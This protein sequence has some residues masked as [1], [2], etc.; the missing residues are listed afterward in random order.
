MKLEEQ[1]VSLELSK[2]LKELG[3]PQESLW[4]W[5]KAHLV[6]VKKEDY[7]IVDKKYMLPVE[8]SAF[9][10]AE[11]GE[12]LPKEIEINAWLY[13]LIYRKYQ[14]KYQISLVGFTLVNK[15]YNGKDVGTHKTITADTEANA[16]A[17]MVIYLKENKLI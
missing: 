16:R 3:V 9:T 7:F 13:E 4:W 11:L 12:M 10:V 17:K 6:D 1:V 2:K 14:G 15:I 5:A 8:C